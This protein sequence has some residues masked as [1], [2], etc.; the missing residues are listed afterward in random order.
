[1]SQAARRASHG[2]YAYGGGLPHWRNPQGFT[3]SGGLDDYVLKPPPR[4][5]W[6]T[7][8]PTATMGLRRAFRASVGSTDVP[9]KQLR[10][11]IHSVRLLQSA[12]EELPEEFRPL[13]DVTGPR[14]AAVRSGGP[15]PSLRGA[16]SVVALPPTSAGRE[17]RPSRP[18]HGIPRAVHAGSLIGSLMAAC[19][20]LL[21]PVPSHLGGTN[22]ARNG[23]QR[24][25]AAIRRP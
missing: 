22:P 7:Y 8:H 1:V 5:C 12:S 4:V 14:R 10:G 17:P 18:A 20:C 6:A 11:S 13:L 2:C 3:R 16:T 15:V 19:C 23:V 21:V 24:A 9:G 25:R